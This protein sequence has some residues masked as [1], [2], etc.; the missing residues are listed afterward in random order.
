VCYAVCIEKNQQLANSTTA[1]NI[2]H[3]IVF[4]KNV[5]LQDFQIFQEPNSTFINARQLVMVEYTEKE[6]LST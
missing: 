2:F 3:I 5:N 1:V 6:R 4:D